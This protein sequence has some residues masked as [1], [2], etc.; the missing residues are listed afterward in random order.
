M[1]TKL[2]LF[3]IFLIF[4][5]S[6]SRN[7]NED[8]GK[9]VFH[10]NEAAGIVSL[11]PAFAKDQACIWACNQLYNGLVQLDDNLQVLPCIA[12]SWEI[13]QDGLLYTFHL[14]NDVFFHDHKL[15]FNSKGRK[16]IA[17][18]FVYSFNRI[19]DPK[20]ASP[21]AWI[22][23]NVN[24]SMTDKSFNFKALNDST[25][26]IALKKPF[27]PFLGLL[28][29][30]YCSVVPKEIVENYG[31]DFRKNP[32]GTGP[33][34][35]KMWKEG[36][37]LVLVKN[38]NYFEYDGDKRLPYLDAV[39]ITFIT[40]KQSVFLEFLKGNIDFLN[41]IDPAYK[42]EL[43]TRSGKLNPK[44]RAQF[45]MLTEPYLNTEYLGFLVDS[46]SEV[47]KNSP[48]YNKKIRQAINYGFDRK[49]MIKYLRNNIG[50]PGNY[51]M[52]PVGMPSFDSIAMKGYEYNPEKV[53]ELLK[54]AGYPGGDGLADISISTTSTYLDL[55]EY[56]Q[57]QLSD[58]GI[59]IKI[60][61]NPPATLREMV[62]NSKLPFF[63]GSWIA[64]YPDAENYLSL[65][66]SKNY[67]PQGPNYT[68][69]SNTT[70]DKL[71]ENAQRETNDS[72]RYS[73]YVKM[74][75]IAMD[76]APVVILYYDQ[77]LRFTQKNISGLTSNPMNLLTLKQ[78]K[79]IKFVSN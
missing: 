33:F 68:H 38:E 19:I 9:T 47:F 76:E 20:L 12:K 69:F 45:N 2:F 72:L 49:K 70:F 8:K 74:N 46:A 3:F 15:F 57:Q 21:G 24:D 4:I 27:P 26:L 41:S 62:A 35:F 73:Y 58:F 13:S 67:C 43:L 51:G 30:Q 55:C 42:D 79:K 23:N 28:S 34:K 22:F 5:V 32:V 25:L 50:T 44:Y 60:E 31:K 65:F 56:I 18:D 52:I 36:V 64:D 11:D 48:L 39:A 40:D 59:K 77:V 10:Y 75:K 14:R 53:R 54:E 17:S 1:K 78:V 37:K 63:R 29:M 71:Y 61:V 7:T 66:Y 6:C 16:I